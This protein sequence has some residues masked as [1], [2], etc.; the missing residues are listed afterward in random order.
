MTPRGML[1]S[2][3]RGY[4]DD[5]SR[6][7]PNNSFD[8]QNLQYAVR[9]HR[10]LL[11]VNG[12]QDRGVSRARFMTVLRDQ[13]RPAVLI[14]G[15]YLSNPREAEHIADPAYRQKLAEAVARAL[16]D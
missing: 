11:A 1:S 13:N 8:G 2:L 16:Y 7:F 10:A 4:E 14:E 9:L 12:S 6:V 3:T 5:P 15:G